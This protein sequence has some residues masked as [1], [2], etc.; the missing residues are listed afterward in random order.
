[1]TRSG[2]AVCL[3]DCSF[4][5]FAGAEG[6]ATAAREILER[7]TPLATFATEVLGVTIE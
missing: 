7:Q 4:G 3:G 5:V 6:G 2:A 1:M